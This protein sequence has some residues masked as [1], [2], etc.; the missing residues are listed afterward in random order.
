MISHPNEMGFQAATR[1]LFDEIRTH[2]AL[3]LYGLIP[4]NIQD[5][6]RMARMSASDPTMWLSYGLAVLAIVGILPWPFDNGL[7][8]GFKINV[9]D[10]AIASISV[11]INCAAGG[12]WM[13]CLSRLTNDPYASLRDLERSVFNNVY[14]YYC[15]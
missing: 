2:E 14:A 6:S 4:P 10:T 8:W 7:H 12:A 5:A 1:I 3:F 15:S 13:I 11:L 9:A